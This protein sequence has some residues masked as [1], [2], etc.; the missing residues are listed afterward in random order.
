MGQWLVEHVEYISKLR[1]NKIL[2]LIVMMEIMNMMIKI[3]IFMIVMMITMTK[4]LQLPWLCGQNISF[5]SNIS[6][7]IKDQTMKFA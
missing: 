3:V 7:L 2:E 5:S 1:K 6:G 4:N